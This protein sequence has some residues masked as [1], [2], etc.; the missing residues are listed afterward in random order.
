MGILRKVVF[1]WQAGGCP[2]LSTHE[3]R[4][5]HGNSKEKDRSQESNQEEACCQENRHEKEEVVLKRVSQVRNRAALPSS[6]S[7]QGGAVSFYMDSEDFYFKTAFQGEEPTDRDR[8]T[9]FA[10]LSC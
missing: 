8:V 1:L 2:C 7:E 3:R 6:R 5:E 4:R 9:S 10:D